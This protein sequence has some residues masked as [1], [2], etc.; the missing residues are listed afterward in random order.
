MSIQIRA[1]VVDQVGAPFT[2]TDLLVD[3]PGPGEILVRMVASGVCHTDANTRSGD[4]PLPL[5]GVLGHEGA[6]IVEAVGQDV[7]TPAVGDH[8]VL[9]WPYCGECKN[10]LEGEPRYC[11]SIGGALVGGARL[12]GEKAGKSGYHRL[13]GSP[14]SGHFFGQSSFATHSL[15]LASQAVVVPSDVPLEIVGPLACGIATGAGAVLNTAQPKVGQRL[16]VYGVGAVGLAAIMAASNTPATTI[17][18]VDMHESRLDLAT[19]YGATHV[20]NASTTEDVVAAI[21]E[22]TGGPADFA[23][24]CTG[25]IKV[26]E[27]VIDTVGMLGTAILIGGAPAGARFSVDHFGALFGKRIVGTLGGS[28]RS[29]RLIPALIDLWRQGRFPFDELVQYFDFEDIEGAL[30]ASRCGDVIKPV[31]TFLQPD[32]LSDCVSGRT[33]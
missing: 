19:K 3:E 17:V 4:M 14:V 22:I 27:Q 9:G 24:D 20:V 23:L 10:C 6:G 28:G 13:D 26:V 33:A 25:V 5:P 18:A 8:V 11:L 15:A 7:T 2:Y 21:Q 29:E 31:I 30:E 12:T 16:V 1:S 32:R